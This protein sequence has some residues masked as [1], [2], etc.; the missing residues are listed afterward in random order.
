MARPKKNPQYDPEIVLQ[1][2]M[3]E[4]VTL[5]TS[6]GNKKGLS[7]RQ[8]AD[9]LDMT[10]LKV[11]KLLISAGVFV[12]DICNQ[13]QELKEDGKTIFEIQK[14]T[15]LSR[16]SVH[17]YLPYSKIVYNAKEISLNA[18][19]I[20]VYR[21]RKIQV[22]F[23]K[24]QVKRNRNT[25]ILGNELWKVVRVFENYPFYTMKG[26]RY[27]YKIKENELFVGRK[28]KGISKST[29]MQAMQKVME[30]KQKVKEPEQLEVSGASYLYPLFLKIGL[31][32]NE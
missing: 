29:V 15:G 19:R 21:D 30:L 32:E 27:T 8:I 10:S 12:S 24:E 20:R 3:N 1:K 13:V 16:A 23:F 17:S 2:I 28:E 6:S 25:E 14:I 4:V 11:R 9:E 7:I 5:Y 22:S 31:I 18:E 26:L